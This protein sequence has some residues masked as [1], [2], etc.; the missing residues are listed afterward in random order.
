[1]FLMLLKQG[2]L[3]DTC[4]LLLSNIGFAYFFE[5]PTLNLFFGYKY[6]PKI[7][8]KPIFDTI[9]GAIFSQGLYVPIAATFLT[10]L[11]KNW[12]WK[13][14]F[15]LGYFCIENIFVRLK[16]YK[17]YWWKP[18]LTPVLITL[19]FYI[20]DYFYKFLLE[21]KEWAKKLAHYLSIEVLWI[22]IMY[23]SAMKRYIRFG[24]KKH[25]WVEHFKIAPLYSIVLSLIATITSARDGFIYKLLLPISQLVLDAT[26]VKWKILKV[27]IKN[28]LFTSSRYLVMP[29]VSR[30]FYKIIYKKEE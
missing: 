9:L 14:S 6:K 26:L 20:S 27:D 4:I 16:I 8:K 23:F 12:K 17:V 1:M 21:Q 29:F 2:K 5:Y 25:T 22:T 28:I 19:Y 10:T 18:L 3:K 13:L 7:M 11:K 24:W 30:Y 15:S